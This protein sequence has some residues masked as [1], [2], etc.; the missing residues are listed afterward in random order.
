MRFENTGKKVSQ[1]DL[2]IQTNTVEEPVDYRQRDG[3]HF[4]LR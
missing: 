1:E 4:S 2:R 3:M